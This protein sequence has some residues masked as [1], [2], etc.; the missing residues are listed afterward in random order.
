MIHYDVTTPDPATALFLSDPAPPG[1]RF[2]LVYQLSGAVLSGEFQMQ[3]P[4]QPAWKSY[5]EWTGARQ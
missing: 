4:G 1:P 2:R 3:L 5:L